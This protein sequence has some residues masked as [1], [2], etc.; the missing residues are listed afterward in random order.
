MPTNYAYDY[1]YDYNRT[2]AAPELDPNLRPKP[3]AKPSQERKLDL[4]RLEKEQLDLQS[5][6][7]AAASTVLN[8]IPLVVLIVVACVILCS[9]Y[10]SVRSKRLSYS[11][12]LSKLEIYKSQ[13][14]EVDAKLE[15]LVTPDK[16]AKIAVEKLGMVKLAE[17]NK[18]Y[19]VSND[20][21]EVVISK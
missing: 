1:D 16:I 14:V 10:S 18:S 6:Q 8:F 5:Q 2:N 12:N 19:A 3:K 4:R 20:E 21:N 9:S 11:R 7:R 17:E 15:M 13:Q